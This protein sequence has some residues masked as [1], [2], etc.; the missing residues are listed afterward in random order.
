MSWARA[1]GTQTG[2]HSLGTSRGCF[3]AGRWGGGGCMETWRVPQKALSRWNTATLLM[4]TGQRPRGGGG[5][6]WPLP[7]GRV[8][9]SSCLSETCLEAPLQR[10]VCLR[11]PSP[12][13]PEPKH[14]PRW[15]RR[16]GVRLPSAPGLRT[17]LFTSAPR[18]K[19]L[20]SGPPSCGGCWGH[21]QRAQ[22]VR[23]AHTHATVHSAHSESS[24]PW[25]L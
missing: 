22:T 17:H 5:C 24:L 19:A 6:Q 1:G 12:P 3:E 2:Q 20:L 13:T 21:T 11:L 15:G 25:S 8:G 10:P 4:V 23:G 16:K 7:K 18:G 9:W 14:K